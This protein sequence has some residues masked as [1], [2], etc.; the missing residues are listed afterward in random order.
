MNFL[1]LILLLC[2]GCSSQRLETGGGDL[3]RVVVVPQGPRI[4]WQYPES[5]SIL[6]FH[7]YSTSELKPLPW[8]LYATI[9]P[10]LRE[11]KI[12]AS[13][14]RRFFAL[15]AFN[16]NGDSDYATK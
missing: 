16:A 5:E 3:A 12:P 7:L 1:C 10:D 11:W 8:P 13:D 15:T 6:G 4:L 14:E 2:A 9:E